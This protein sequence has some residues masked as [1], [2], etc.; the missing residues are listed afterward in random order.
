[1]SRA[2][3]VAAV[4]SVVTLLL[5][6]CSSKKKSTSATSKT[7]AVPATTA[8][9]AATTT[10]AGAPK[11]TM[12]VT[13]DTGLKDAQTVHIVGKGFTAGSSRGVIECADKGTATGAGDCDLG[14]I[15]TATVAADGTVTL[16]Y[17]VK[18][19]PFGS[20]NIVCSATVKCLLSMNDLSAAPKELATANISFA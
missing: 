8:A 6:A 2:I 15:K 13:P 11:Q 19:G 14:G 5:G 7:T 12:T 16:D 17:P 20:N 4:I 18:K 3:K 9:P 1:M 10:T